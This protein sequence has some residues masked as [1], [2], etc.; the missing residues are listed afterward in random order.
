VKIHCGEQG[1]NRRH[2]QLSLS[3]EEF[4]HRRL[5][6]RR[7]MCPRPLPQTISR[8]L[9][10]LHFSRHRLAEDAPAQRKPAV[11]IAPKAMKLSPLGDF[12][13][14]DDALHGRLDAVEVGLGSGGY[15]P[16]RFPHHFTG[17]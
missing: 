14:V 6:E 7:I 15:V 17:H 10:P 13:H 1:F 5:G 2:F 4:M 8:E 3:L 12:A 9:K 11:R 16:Y